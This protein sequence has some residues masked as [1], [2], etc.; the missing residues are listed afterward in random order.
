VIHRDL[1]PKNVLVKDDECSYVKLADFGVS[2]VRESHLTMT[3][4]ECVGTPIYMAPEMHR[5]EPYNAA[6]DVFSFA[7]VCWELY[8][9]EKPFRGW[10]QYRLIKGVGDGD[11]RPSPVPASMPSEVVTLMERCW[12][13]ESRDRPGMTEVVSKLDAMLRKMSA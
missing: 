5:N 10:T 9:L 7:L 6:V 3:R 11:V 4:A 12:Q 13:K 8:S 1:N 2:R